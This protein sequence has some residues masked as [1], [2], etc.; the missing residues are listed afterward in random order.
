LVAYLDVAGDKDDE[1]GENPGVSSCI[2]T[3]VDLQTS[4]MLSSEKT[5]AKHESVD[6]P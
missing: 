5:L 4:W 2:H 1:E 3:K 6:V